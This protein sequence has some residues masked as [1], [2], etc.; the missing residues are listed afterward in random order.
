MRLE[1]QHLNF[2]YL[3]GQTVLHDVSLTV[4]PG[5]TLFILGRN[6]SGKSTLVSCLAGL[7]H[8][9]SGG[10][11]L[12]GEDIQSLSAAERARKVG[13]IPQTHTPAFGYTVR[14]MVLM[15]RAP[16]LGWL[17]APS[18]EDHAIVDDA[19]AQVGIFELADRP[20]TEISGGE[21]QLVL[22]ARGLAQQCQVLLMDE[23][24]AHLDLSNRH[25][26]L[27]IVNQLSERGLSFVICSHSPNNALAYADRVL[28]LTGGWVTAQG[29]PENTLTESLLSSV[30]GIRTEVILDGGRPVAVVTQRPIALLPESLSDPDSLLS[31][32]FGQRGETPQLILVTGLSGVGKTTWCS[33]LIE[34]AR[35]AGMTVNGVL[36]PGNFQEERKV[37]I[38]VLNLGTGEGRQL[39]RLRIDQAVQVSTPRWEF[40]PEALDWANAALAEAAVGDLLVIDELGPLEFFQGKGLTAGLARLDAGDYKVACVVIRSALLPNALQRWPHAI[41]VN[42]SAKNFKGG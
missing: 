25:R 16:H 24:T 15:G 18:R 29:G 42:G 10:V 4:E 2:A 5:E 39:A 22:I 28:L 34:L 31:E 17:G 7:I 12:D 27:E 35:T 30:Y 14:E 36:S 20:Y 21:G 38:D 26:V 23:P 6:G 3:P 1:A 41:V 19:L 9:D 13:L 11:T 8:P 32:V 40:D 33:R 37:G